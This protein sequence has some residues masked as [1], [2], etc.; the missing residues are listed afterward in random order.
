MGISYNILKDY[1][2]AIEFLNK[3]KETA[4]DS[5]SDPESKKIW[6]A[7]ADLILSEIEK[8]KI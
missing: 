1:D 5:H 7:I 4:N 2:M 8:L 6:I 3:G